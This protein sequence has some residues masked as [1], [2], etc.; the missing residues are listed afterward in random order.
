MPHNCNLQLF[1]F[2]FHQNTFTYTQVRAASASRSPFPF[3][4]TFLNVQKFLWFP[5]PPLFPLLFLH[6]TQS[7]RCTLCS[8]GSCTSSH[9]LQNKVSP[10]GFFPFQC[11][12]I[13]PF[14][15]S[16]GADAPS[17]AFPRSA[18][19]CTAPTVPRE[20]HLRVH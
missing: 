13:C 16:A 2:F 4:L 3:Q 14:Q 12:S 10:P 5:V 9:S 20:T 18:L 7:G 15:S 1:L 6:F 17:G 19:C 8:R 11:I